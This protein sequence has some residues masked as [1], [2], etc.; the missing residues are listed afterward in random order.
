MM[1]KISL[2]G[3]FFTLCFNTISA[4]ESAPDVGKFINPISDVCW[5]CLFPIHI[6]GENIT[7]KEKPLTK[8]N[9]KLTCSCAG[10]IVGLPL[11]FWEPTRLIDV[12]RTPYKLVG[13]GGI[14][15]GE[16]L[17]KG[18]GV[19]GSSPS[20]NQ[21]FYHVHYYQF[22]LLSLLEIFGDFLCVEDF[23]LDI[24]YLSELDPFWMNDKWTSILAPETV[25]F[26]TPP[27]QL[28][29]I[30]DC[31]VSTFGKPN[32]KLFWCGGCQG[33]LYP[34]TG[35]IGHH[36][37]PIRSSSLLVHRILAK[38]HKLGVLKTFS[39]DEY[40]C[41]KRS[42]FIKKAA[43]KTQLAYPVAQTKGSC[44]PLG[45]STLKW[46]AFKSYP[47]KGED[48]TYVI[49]TKKHCCLDP[50][51]MSSSTAGAVIQGGQK[52]IDTIGGLGE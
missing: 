51:K 34:L 8:Y 17:K 13:L 6:M 23:P 5:S 27:A 16:N 45:K 31:L 29:C 21:S 40:C 36:S 35:F 1:K 19:F 14:Q 10:G 20:E 26:G 44:N 4:N 46:G 28:A 25:L 32:D 3:L 30:P 52:V 2:I 41:P 24:G 33:N 38:L 39:K 37:G 7:K 18:G 15:I 11:A 48:F 9:Q 49:W 12:T 22:P 47:Y 43:Y 50:V 42:R